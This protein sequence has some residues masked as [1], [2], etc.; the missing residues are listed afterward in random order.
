MSKYLVTGITGFAGPHLA[1]LLLSEGHEV[2]GLVRCSNGRE[3][4]IRDV[5]PDRNMARIKFVYGDLTSKSRVDDIVKS[6]SY[7]GVFHLAAQSHPPTSFEDPVGTFEANAHGTLNLACSIAE[8][9]PQTRL[10]FCSTS[11]VYGRVSG[12][13]SENHPLR[14][15]NPYGASKAHADLF[16]RLMAKTDKLPF[17][18]TRAFSHTGPRRGRR[19]SISSDAFQIARIIKGLQEPVIRVGKL[20]ST[21]V[22]VDVRDCDAAYYALMQDKFIPGEAYNVGGDETYSMGEVLDMMLEMR[23]LNG[24]VEIR[25]DPALVRPI[26]FGAQLPNS[27]KIREATGWRPRIPIRETLGDLLNYWERKVAS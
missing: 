26:G 23:D 21:R 1:N 7:D 12:E 8:L 14:P 19:F 24:R 9:S 4:D 20:E 18:V 11:E 25:R 17:F 10:M 22:V 16:V 2:E 13:T 5:V 27:D 3:E 15:I 6:G